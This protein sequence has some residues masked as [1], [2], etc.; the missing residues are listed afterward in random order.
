M[1]S[2][3]AFY[4]LF[5]VILIVNT[6]EIINYPNY[7]YT[8]LHLQ[9]KL[10]YKTGFLH[11]IFL[12]TNLWHIIKLKNYRGSFV[13]RK[14]VQIFSVLS[15]IR[16][17][18]LFQKKYNLKASKIRKFILLSYSAVLMVFT[19]SS[20]SKYVSEFIKPDTVFLKESELKYARKEMDIYQWVEEFFPKMKEVIIWCDQQD[21][22]VELVTFDPEIMWMNYEGLSRVY[23]TNCYYANINS[24]NKT[25]SFV[26]KKKL[27][28]VSISSC[29]PE[30][31]KEKGNPN[32][33]HIEYFKIINNQHICNSEEIVPSL[34]LYN[35]E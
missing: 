17:Q 34:Y 31:A 10:L 25:H 24:L 14:S 26:G 18:L 33:D 4:L 1:L 23:L 29:D 7:I 21:G 22:P 15:L 27:R 2:V 20:S 13:S 16:F 8:H 12:Y 11:F 6:L 30:L 28:L 32:G 3:N 9:P 35:G 5:L 19:L